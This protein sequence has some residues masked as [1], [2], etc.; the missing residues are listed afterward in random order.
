MN[1]TEK[2]NLI[3]EHIKSLA[4][5]PYQAAFEFEKQK[6]S[7]RQKELENLKESSAQAMQEYKAAQKNEIDFNITDD[8]ESPTPFMR[9]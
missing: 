5:D 9:L 4:P 3:R 8:S 7:D 6:W 2:F 1:W